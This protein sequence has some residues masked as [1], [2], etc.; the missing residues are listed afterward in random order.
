MDTGNIASQLKEA[1]NECTRLKE[2]NKRLRVL[3][4]LPIE[5]NKKDSHSVEVAPQK[6]NITIFRSLFRGRE[7][8]F[9]IRWENKQGRSG[10]SP[11]CANEWN[12]LFCKKPKV[13]C[14]DCENREFIP[15][16]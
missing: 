16:T 3:L 12:R 8:V 10:Y 6:D 5:T 7:D 9:P 15:V 13:K 4:G 14:A 11:A 2:E 1:L